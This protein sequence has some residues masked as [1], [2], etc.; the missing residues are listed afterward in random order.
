MLGIAWWPVLT[1]TL[2]GSSCCG[3]ATG[4]PT[5]VPTPGSGLLGL[6]PSITLDRGLVPPAGTAHPLPQTLRS[7]EGAGEGAG[8]GARAQEAFSLG[9]KLGAG[10]MDAGL[11]TCTGP[12]AAW[13]LHCRATELSSCLRDSLAHCSENPHSLACPGAAASPR[14]EQ[15]IPSLSG[16]AGQA[17]LPVPGKAEQQGPA[18]QIGRGLH[19]HAICKLGMGAR[20]RTPGALPN[21]VI[22][23]LT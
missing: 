7:R 1:G 9:W 14:F 6:P 10:G 20:M 21:Q 8:E 22:Q 18:C 16:H 23:G 2:L 12:V 5:S 11:L 13:C 15:V 19:P 17:G 4:V 3:K